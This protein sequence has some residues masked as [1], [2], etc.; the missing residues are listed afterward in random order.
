MPLPGDEVHH[1]L[2]HEHRGPV[3]VRVLYLALPCHNG[4]VSP[5][6]GHSGGKELPFFSTLVHYCLQPWHLWFVSTMWDWER[7]DIA[8]YG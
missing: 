1:S 7:E 6:A 5:E 2:C 8:S 3:G 4:P